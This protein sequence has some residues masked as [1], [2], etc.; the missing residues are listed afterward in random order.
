MHILIDVS[1]AA[2]PDPTGIGNYA[3]ELI[4]QLFEIDKENRYTFGIRPKKYAFRE[5]LQNLGNGRAGLLP[6][7]PPFYCFLRGRVDIFHSLH[8]S[9][10]PLRLF[11]RVVTIHD[12][13]TIEAAELF[14][15]NWAEKRA[16]RMVRTL[17][18]ADAIITPSRFTRDRILERFSIP[19]N[20]IRVVFH[21]VNHA[22]FY[23]RPS[24][25]AAET[26]ARYGLE[27]PFI[28]HIGSYNPR[29]NKLRLVQSFQRSRASGD[30]L[31]VLVGRRRGDYPEI[32][33]EVRRLGLEKKVRFLDYVGREDIPLLLAACRFFAFPSYYEGFGLPVLEAMA[34]G[35]PVAASKASAVPEVAE[36]VAEYFDPNSLEE[37]TAVFD[38]LWDDEARRRDLASRG[39]HRAAL[40]T[41]REAAE[42]TLEVYRRAV[43]G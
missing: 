2:R 15:T 37:M 8:H 35:I 25:L 20:R 23:P 30:G 39:P 7:V 32:L 12:L 1:S 31:L 22:H 17:R 42:Q 11:R 26:A 10:P 3:R 41:W 16:T 29:K 21:G 6:I 5:H 34:T 27:R 36:D 9:L 14:D 13:D 24:P 38:R 43:S 4:T 33:A 19:A 40:F 18:R 28:L